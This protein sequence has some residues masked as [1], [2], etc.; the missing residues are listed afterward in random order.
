VQIIL[1]G[2]KKTPSPRVRTEGK[3]HFQKKLRKGVFVSKK[4]KESGFGQF[5][6]EG[7]SKHKRERVIGGKRST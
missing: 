4:V 2:K 6:G 1:G 7:S 5:T 3:A